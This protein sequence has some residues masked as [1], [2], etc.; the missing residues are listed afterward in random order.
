MHACDRS[1]IHTYPWIKNRFAST[2]Y[3]AKGLFKTAVRDDNPVM[4]F[5]HKSLYDTRGYVPEEEYIIPFG[6]A[7]VKKEGKDVTLV[8]TLGGI[9]LIL[10]SSRH[11]S[12]HVGV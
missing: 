9:S 12:P 11:I 10:T 1:S 5:E 4:F 7:D 3:E 8:A 6:V 2:P